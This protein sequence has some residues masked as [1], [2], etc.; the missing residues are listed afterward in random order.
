M[1]ATVHPEG[2]IEVP[3]NGGVEL[4]CEA[5]GY[6]T[7]VVTWRKGDHPITSAQPNKNTFFIDGV[8]GKITLE[9]FAE[10][11][12]GRVVKVA[13]IFS[14][15]V[16]FDIT[17]YSKVFV[18]YFSFRLIIEKLEDVCNPKPSFGMDGN[19]V[20][21][22]PD[23]KG[24]VQRGSVGN[25]ASENN[26]CVT[27]LFSCIHF[28]QKFII[29]FTTR[30]ELPLDRWHSIETADP[31][32]VLLPNLQGLQRYFVR[33]KILSP[34]DGKSVVCGVFT[35][36]VPSNSDRRYFHNFNN[37]IS[38]NSFQVCQKVSFLRE[39]GM[40]LNFIGA[41]SKFRMKTLK[42]F[43]LTKNSLI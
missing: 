6:P 2:P 39:S 27:I 38:K 15:G 11:D 40:K 7:P 37:V 8:S 43:I 23:L 10:N 35:T 18:F 36:V 14:S 30:G 5:T 1:N 41:L 16:H 9:C 34:E 20:V 25:F 29:L 19:Y 24:Q 17:I 4:I 22:W 13:H 12:A 3:L 28:F 33:M 32:L 31:S 26:L 42:Y 21:K